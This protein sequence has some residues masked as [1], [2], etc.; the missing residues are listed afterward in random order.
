ML[1]YLLLFYI[2]FGEFGL[3]TVPVAWLHD[4]IARVYLQRIRGTFIVRDYSTYAF[5]APLSFPVSF[6][7]RGFY[8]DWV[9]DHSVDLGPFIDID[10]CLSTV[11]L[12]LLG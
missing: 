11:E 5:R 3:D 7:D 10:A 9:S 8:E 6:A 4:A 1:A 2:I 12:N